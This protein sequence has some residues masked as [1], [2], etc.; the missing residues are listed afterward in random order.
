MKIRRDAW[1]A[2][3]VAAALLTLGL[4]PALAGQGGGRQ[5]QQWERLQPQQRER[6]LQEQQ[7][8][9]QLPPQQQQRLRQEYE[10]RNRR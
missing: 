8:F 5:Y 3:A 1:Q 9:R 4:P 10:Q 7:R 6:I 2:A